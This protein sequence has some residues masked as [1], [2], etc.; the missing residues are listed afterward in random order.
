MNLHSHTHKKELSVDMLNG[1]LLKKMILFALPLAASSMLQQLFNAADTAVVGRFASRQAM[2]AVGSNSPVINLIVGLFVGISIGANVLISSL[3]GQNVT[4]RIEEAIHTCIAIA[5]ITGVI[6]I[7][8]GQ[9]LC[10]PLLRLAQTPDDVFDLAVLYLRIYFLGMPFVMLYNFGSAILRSRGDSQRPLYALTAAGVINVILNLI[11]VIGFHLHVIGVAMAT[12]I[13]NGVSAS[14]IIW[15]LCREEEPFH[16]DFKA[17][18]INRRHLEKI[19]RIGL[20]AGVQGM[21][22]SLSNTV[23]LS[24]INSFGSAASA[25]SAAAFNMEIFSYYAVNAF[26]LTA[27]TFTGQNYAAGKYD[28]CKTV[29]RNAMLCA[30]ISCLSMDLIFFF[31]RDF[32]LGIFSKDPEVLSYATIRFTHVLLLHV[33]ICSY[34]ITGAALRGMG[35]SMTP[36]LIMVFGTCVFRVFWTAVIFP[37]YRDFGVLLNV[38]PASWILTGTLVLAAYFI[39]R[40]RAFNPGP[41]KSSLL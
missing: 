17:L 25:G 3:I 36:S 30:V 16:L 2:A 34:E 22:F 31:G 35:Y 23:I 6:L 20:P 18:R 38:Y 37:R 32:F 9:L 13:S 10:A 7:G 29:F 1:P 27:V 11:F 24:Q 4:D 14:L 39:V 19:L 26:N 15:F 21:V 41:S 12:V 5:L 8:V 33:L 28:R 40:K